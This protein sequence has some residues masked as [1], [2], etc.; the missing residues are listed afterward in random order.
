MGRPRKHHV[1]QSFEFKSHGGKRAGAG[2]PRK[3]K[4]SSERHEK[5]EPHDRRHPVHVTIRVVPGLGTLRKRHYYKAIRWATIAVAAHAR[6]RIVHFSIQSNHMHLLVEATSQR[7]LARGMKGFQISAAKH[8][9]RTIGER[10][11]E[12]RRRGQVFADRY[13]KHELTSPREVRH[14]L[15]Y[16]L[17][18]WRRHGED[19]TRTWKLDPYSTAVDFGGWKELGDSPFLYRT[20][21]TYEGLVVWRPRTWLLQKGWSKHGQLSVYEVPGPAP[22]S[23]ARPRPRA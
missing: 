3:G 7:A 17:N 1:Q 5:R 18:N 11:G 22:A 15:A 8:I 16:V 14:A 10:N 4:R 9:N 6:F 23:A 19:A 20:P 2:R 12:P 21:P 13:H